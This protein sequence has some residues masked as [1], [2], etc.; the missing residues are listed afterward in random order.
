[1]PLVRENSQFYEVIKVGTVSGVP[2]QVSG[3]TSISSGTV[4]GTFVVSNTS[5]NPI[6]VTDSGSSLTVDGKAYRSM[7]Q[8]TR[9]NDASGYIAGDVIGTSGSAIHTLSGAGPSGGYI[10]I[11]SVEFII[12][13]TSVPSGM[14]AFR[15]HFY[16]STPSGIVDNAAFNLTSGEASSYV[17]YVDLP[18]PLDLGSTLYAQTDYP[19]RLIQLA[20]GSTSLFCEIQ[21]VNAYTPASGTSHMFRIKT[22]EAGL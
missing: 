15:T 19:G 1:M 22:L 20:S 2:V 6:P 18:T 9:P 16:T 13:A 12:D 7:V 14:G 17:G 5:S 10:I 21:T 4:T 8:F 11:Q 3:V